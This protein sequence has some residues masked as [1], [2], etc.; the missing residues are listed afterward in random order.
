[1]SL[2]DILVIRNGIPIFHHSIGK[3]LSEEHVPL[4]SGLLTAL[5]DLAKFLDTEGISEIQL[6]RSLLVIR[7]I[8]D[9]KVVC[10]IAK[11]SDLLKIQPMFNAMNDVL[12]AFVSIYEDLDQD[13]D[14]SNGLA[15]GITEELIFIVNTKYLARYG[16]STPLNLI[17][18]YRKGA[19]DIIAS[20]PAELETSLV[21]EIIS[22]L[23]KYNEYQVLSEQE[24][25]FFYLENNNDFVLITPVRSDLPYEIFF[26]R[27]I[28][29]DEIPSAY[30]SFP[31]LQSRANSYFS[32]LVNG[33]GSIQDS[34]QVIRDK[35]LAKVDEWSQ[36][37]ELEDDISSMYKIQ[38]LT[39]GFQLLELS[40]G[41]FLEYLLYALLA[42][43]TI[44][45][46]G[47]KTYLRY[48]NLLIK[49]I[50]PYLSVSQVDSDKSELYHIRFI[51]SRQYLQ[52]LQKNF[53][54]S[55]DFI[56]DLIRK[57]PVQ[58]PT[59]DFCQFIIDEMERST[60]G[61]RFEIMYDLLTWFTH[62]VFTLM[63]LD[64]QPSLI[65][66]DD[67]G[68]FDNDEKPASDLLRKALR[69]I[70]ISPSSRM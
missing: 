23:E 20:H 55:Q 30:I 58:A 38:D 18:A 69:N 35:A 42:H 3:G 29:K 27:I 11:R 25:G 67:M 51:S 56:Y 22:T 16:R 52:L 28:S 39:R 37:S 40:F 24:S 65:L 17:L 10:K 50:F 47:T 48:F 12:V 41:D 34:I 43:N 9:F 57:R 53:F 45:F 63:S 44:Y 1:M 4:T 54:N 62:K 49:E 2:T 14:L 66:M 70:G 60:T 26:L 8:G 7:E 32:D 15:T 13:F 61:H 59:D 36:W 6:G 31:L 33:I 5:V 21:D 68:F 19:Y 46:I 64:I